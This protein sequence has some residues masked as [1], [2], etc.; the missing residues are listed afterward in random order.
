M[1]CSA[2]AQTINVFL[3]KK[4]M[5]EVQVSLA[6]GEAKFLNVPGTPEP[7]LKKGIES[8]G[9][10]IADKSVVKKYPNKFARYLAI[11][12]PLT[13]LLQLPMLGH[14]PL[15]HWLHYSWVQLMICLPVYITGMHFFGRS[16][17]NS[18]KLGTYNMNLYIAFQA[19]FLI[20][21]SPFSFM[22]HRQLL[23]RWF[24]SETIWKNVPCVRPRKR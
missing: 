16:A 17:I 21:E 6:A 3:E 1:S 18:I 12:V 5:K 8:L 4:G 19:L 23:L 7:E 14:G 13:L 24:S 10:H 15:L 20:L 2:C 9:Y 11:C 22:R